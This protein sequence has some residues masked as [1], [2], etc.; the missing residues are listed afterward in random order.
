MAPLLAP[1]G[2]KSKH[3]ATVCHHPYVVSIR[4]RGATEGLAPGGTARGEAGP[5]PSTRIVPWWPALGP[6]Q[7]TTRGTQPTGMVKIRRGR[8]GR[9]GNRRSAGFAFQLLGLP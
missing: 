1:P 6:G 9:R 4:F 7:V 8:H 2:A 5:P 3:V